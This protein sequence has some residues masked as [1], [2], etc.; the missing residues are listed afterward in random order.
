MC[1]R[2]TDER[3]KETEEEITKDDIERGISDLNRNKAP[4]PDG[5]TAEFY[6]HFKKDLVS[7][8]KKVCDVRFSNGTLSKGTT[9]S[10][11]RLIPKKCPDKK[12]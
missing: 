3:K 12:T 2:L 8:L 1:R 5:L 7:I 4:S 10:F 11:I 9:H 6:K